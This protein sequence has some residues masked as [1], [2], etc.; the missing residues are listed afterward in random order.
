MATYTIDNANSYVIM[1]F[2]VQPFN[3]DGLIT[4]N[5]GIYDLVIGFNQEIDTN[6]LFTTNNTTRHTKFYIHTTE[7]DNG[8]NVYIPLRL[9]VTGGNFNGKQM[10]LKNNTVID[11]IRSQTGN[12]TQSDG[13][14]LD[15]TTRAVGTDVE[16]TIFMYIGTETDPNNIS[17]AEI[18][19]TI[20]RTNVGTLKFTRSFLFRETDTNLNDTAVSKPFPIKT[21]NGN[22]ADYSTALVAY[23]GELTTNE[24]YVYYRMNAGTSNTAT[25]STYT[26][27]TG[28]NSQSDA[29]PV[30]T[31]NTLLYTFTSPAGG[32]NC[33]LQ[34]TKVLTPNGEVN[35]EN[36]NVGDEVMT[37]NNEVRKITEITKNTIIS[38]DSLYKINKNSIQENMPSEDLYLSGGHAIKVDG[39]LFHPFHNKVS[40]TEKCE[41]PSFCNFY[42]LRLE[43]PEDMFY[44]NGVEVESLCDHHVVQ[45]ECESSDNCVRKFL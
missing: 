30:A 31:D 16:F 14:I 6:D 3:G 8:N 41:I 43:K 24:L 33:L 10:M 15:F 27:P 21:N 2:H 18:N 11:Y 13:N 35:I 40:F 37:S 34:G 19:N 4:S 17:Y 12:Y 36:L 26:L 29:T 42:H 25:T 5:F 44:A 45:W 1:G 23:F 22:L 20:K 28:Q 38:G 7:L 9:P 32:I 39:K